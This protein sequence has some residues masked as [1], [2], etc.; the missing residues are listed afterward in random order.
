M[1]K[2]MPATY[3]IIRKYADANHSDHNKVIATGLTLAEAQEH[4]KD[5]S[6]H[7]KGVWFDCFYEE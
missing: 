7:E 4:C 1:P 5:P 2:Y 3:E 6:T